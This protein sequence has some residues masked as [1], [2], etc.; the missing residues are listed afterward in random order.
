MLIQII[1]INRFVY[2]MRGGILT[3]KQCNLQ[4]GGFEGRVNLGRS[5]RANLKATCRT[6]ARKGGGLLMAIIG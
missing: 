2:V 5:A 4:T 3:L 1:S 6:P